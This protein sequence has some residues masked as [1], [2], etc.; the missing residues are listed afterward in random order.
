M[1]DLSAPDGTRLALHDFGGSG[2]PVLLVPGLCG[3]AGEWS[4]TVAW[5]AGT[6]H[7]FGLDPR[8][9]GESER[10]PADVSRAAHVA[11]V[12]TALAVTGP[13]T[14]IGQ[15]LGGHTALLTAAG[16]PELVARL[17]LAEAGPEGPDDDTVRGVDRWLAA[18]PVPFPD[19]AAAAAYLGG[20]L[21]GE[22]WARGL[23]RGPDGWCPTFDR[24]VMVAT[25][26]AAVGPCWGE[27]A[28][29]ACPTLVVTGGAGYLG[30]EECARMG[31]HPLVTAVRID[32]AGHDVH[33]D[34]PRQWRE[35]V[36]GFLAS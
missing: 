2:R 6:H 23:R 19:R 15:S 34:S 32:E 31:Q 36:T 29:I 1:I 26:A 7:V 30:A 33:L 13:A 5:L 22:A 4:A 25:I 20:G 8:G 14:V 9:H 24:E 12:A 10:R 16:H 11:D 3:Y 28:R 27:F 21:V 18:W 35:L 17:V